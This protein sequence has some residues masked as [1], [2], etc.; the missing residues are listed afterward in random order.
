MLQDKATTLK[1]PFENKLKGLHTL[2][3]QQKKNL[4]VYSPLAQAETSN[5]LVNFFG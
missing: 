1:A 4:K 3:K 5:N 2:T